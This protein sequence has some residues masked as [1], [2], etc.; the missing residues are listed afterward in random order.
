M[1]QASSAQFRERKE[2]AITIAGR[3]GVAHL[4]EG[5]VRGAG[6]T[7]RVTADLHPRGGTASEL[8]PHV[9][10]G[11]AGHPRGTA[12]SRARLPTR[13]RPASRRTRR[14]RPGRQ[15]RRLPARPPTSPRSTSTL[16]AARSTTQRR[17]SL[18]ARRARAI[19]CGDRARS[20]LRGGACGAGPLYGD[21]EPVRT[22]HRKPGLYD[23]AIAAARRAIDIA[24]DLADAHSTPGY[25]LFQ[26]R[27][28]ARAAREPFEL[29]RKLGGGEAT[30]SRPMRSTARAPAARAKPPRRSDAP[31][32]ST[33]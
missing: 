20:R 28:D 26:G 9:R 32:A 31:S 5:T 22:H 4:L 19:R 11:P 12:R 27:L 25:T 33:R 1:A 17:R 2:P 29:S 15:R 16:P 13:S 8:V 6:N 24:P 10:A 14:A 21:R 23:E 3:L 18:G 30:R 7:V